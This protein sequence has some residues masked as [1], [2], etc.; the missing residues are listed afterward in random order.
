MSK[1]L[2]G[3]IGAV[4]GLLIAFIFIYQA[5]PDLMMVED[6]SKYSFDETVEVFEEEVREAG[7]SIAGSHDMQ[8]IL[9]G[10]GHDVISI[11][12]FELCSSRYSAEILKLDDERIVSPLMPCRISIYEKSDGNT[13]VTRMNSTLMAR[14]FGGVI[15]EV[16][17]KAAEETEEIIEK[18]IK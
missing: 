8:E 13:Y 11:K 6:E 2:I 3:V 17:Q 9:E 12:I 14:P 5:A 4:A 1:L 18:I 7:W 16:M 10:H 15:N